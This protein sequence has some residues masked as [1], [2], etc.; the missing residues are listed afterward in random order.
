MNLFQCKHRKRCRLHTVGV[1]DK[2]K[3]FIISWNAKISLEAPK[4][5]K[6][7]LYLFFVHL[8]NHQQIHLVASEHWALITVI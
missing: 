1:L 5:F 8:K 3:H 6:T 7:N 2:R 4:T